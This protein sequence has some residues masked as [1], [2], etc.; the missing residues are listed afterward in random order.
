M[1]LWRMIKVAQSCK[2]LQLI[3]RH[4]ESYFGG[5]CQALLVKLYQAIFV[6]SIQVPHQIETFSVK[7]TLTQYPKFSA[8]TASKCVSH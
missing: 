3:C 6:C 1:A 8:A 2:T 5:A 4:L 7:T